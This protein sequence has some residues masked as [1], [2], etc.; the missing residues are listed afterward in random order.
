MI[1][2]FYIGKFWN[3]PTEFSLNQYRHNICIPVRNKQWLL[4]CWEVLYSKYLFLLEVLKQESNFIKKKYFKINLQNFY[5]WNACLYASLKAT[6]TLLYRNII[7]WELLS[8]SKCCISFD[9]SP[10]ILECA[11]CCRAESASHC[12][13]GISRMASKNGLILLLRYGRRMSNRG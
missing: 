6:Q 7:Q 12:L 10:T 9:T 3:I 8:F 4:C 13:V 5:I 2:Q 11:T 1:L